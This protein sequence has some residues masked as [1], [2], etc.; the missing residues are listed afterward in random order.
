[1]EEIIAATMRKGARMVTDAEQQC[2]QHTIDKWT[3]D[4]MRKYNIHANITSN[5]P[6]IYN[7]MQAYLK[8]TPTRLVEHL[9]LAERENWTLGFKLVRG[10][11]I[12]SETRSLIHD[13]KQETDDAYNNIVRSLIRKSL[14]GIQAPFPAFRFIIAGHNE[15]SFRIAMSAYEEAFR[16][17]KANHCLEFGQIQGMADELTCSIAQMGCRNLQSSLTGSHAQRYP[18][19]RVYKALSWGSVQDLMQNLIRRAIENRAAV[20]RTKEWRAGLWRELWR[21]MGSLT[22]LGFRRP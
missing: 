14:P 16:A 17:G 9:K 10:A 5:G 20:E 6:P 2:Y 21:R 22:M 15:E 18:S 13:T 3:L 12:E 11:Y 7:T 8:S 1:M 19:P 4:W